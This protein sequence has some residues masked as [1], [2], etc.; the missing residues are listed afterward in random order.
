MMAGPSPDWL[1]TVAS[2]FSFSLLIPVIAVIT[3]FL[4]TFATAP[5]RKSICWAHTKVFDG[6]NYLLLVDLY[7]GTYAGNS[8]FKCNH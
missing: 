3:N 5:K 6:W 4:G 7:S 2:V 1:E 8:G